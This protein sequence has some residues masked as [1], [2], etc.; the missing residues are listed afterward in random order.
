MAALLFIVYIMYISE[1]L[2]DLSSLVCQK[3]VHLRRSSPFFGACVQNPKLLAKRSKRWSIRYLFSSVAVKHLQR[4]Y[5]DF[6][7]LFIAS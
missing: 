2:Y 4:R 7:Y 1:I 5:E 6:D 3:Q